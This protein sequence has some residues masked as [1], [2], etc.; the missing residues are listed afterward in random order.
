[1]IGYLQIQNF[2]LS[3]KDRK[4]SKILISDFKTFCSSKNL[5]V[6]NL[7][8]DSFHNGKINDMKV[9]SIRVFNEYLKKD[10]RLIALFNNS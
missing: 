10:K 5:K 4:I 3:D 9:F 2:I 7:F 6:L 1:M 8:K